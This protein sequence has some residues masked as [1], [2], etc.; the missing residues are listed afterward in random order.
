MVAR[1]T[2]KQKRLTHRRLSETKG[3]GLMLLE[4]HLLQNFAPANLNRDDTG[5]PKDCEFGGYRR[6]RISSQ[7]LKRAIRTA[8]KDE[9]MLPAERLAQR[10]K[11]VV[12]ALTDRLQAQGKDRSQARDVVARLLEGVNLKLAKE[13]KTEYLLFLG[14]AEIAGAV[15]ICL[16]HWEALAAAVASSEAGSGGRGRSS[17]KKTGRAAGA[18]EEKAA[19]EAFDTLLNGG[20]AADL[21]LFGRMIANLP[22]RNITAACQVAH[23]LSTHKVSMEFDY[24]TAIDDRKPDDTAGADMIGTVEFN[25][26]CFYRYA[27]VDINQLRANLRGDVALADQTV[28]AFIHAAVGAIPTGKQNS[29]AAQNQPSFVMAVVRE[30]G[31]WSLANAFVRPVRPNAEHDLV[32]RSIAELDSY[33]HKLIAM[34]GERGLQGV[35]LATTEPDAVTHLTSARVEGVDVVVNRVL[36][37]VAHD[38]AV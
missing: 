17:A 11:R 5:S 24:Y 3:E 20:K 25:S 13:D 30:R 23:A 38:G 33:W 36:T 26:A 28:N 37:A 12:E 34:Y 31:L 16:T 14:E 1:Q 27:N 19:I 35:W 7:C 32:Q 9:E 22:E 6:A 2:M 21:A 4:L 15:E 10:T 18:G 8:F 29:M